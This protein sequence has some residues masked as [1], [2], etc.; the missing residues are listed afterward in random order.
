MPKTIDTTELD[1]NRNSSDSDELPVLILDEESELL[2]QR[3]KE[4]VGEEKVRAF[5]RR[6][7]ISATALRN[8]IEGRRRPKR[9]AIEK[10]ART[11]SVVYAWLLE[12]RRPKYR[13]EMTQSMSLG[14]M[15]PSNGA[16]MVMEYSKGI[17]PATPSGTI[18]AQLLQLC[19]EACKHVH[20]EAFIKTLADSQILYAADLYNQLVALANAKAP[21]TH[22][23]DFC[24]LDAKALADQLRVFLQMGWAAKFPP[25][26]N[27]SWS[28]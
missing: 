21:A 5:A 19:L 6:A 23:E 24:R 9:D 17:D 26:D 18:N 8:Y 2:R 28:W 10:I 13:H 20:G 3:I 1:P 11:G 25:P 7:Q 15:Q 27:A 12:G 16:A 22:L 14:N 4:V